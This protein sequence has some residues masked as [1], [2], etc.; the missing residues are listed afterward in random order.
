MLFVPG[1][2]P[3]FTEKALTCEA[4]GIIFDLEDAVAV[5]R[6][7]QAREWVRDALLS[8]DF[9]RKERSVRINGLETGF[10]QDDISA[11]VE[12]RPDSIVLPKVNTPEDVLAADA[13]VSRAESAAGLEPNSVRF[14]AFIESPRGVENA[15][16][17]GASCRRVSGFLFGA[18]DFTR[19]THATITESRIELYY[20]LGRILCAARASGIDALDAPCIQVRDPAANERQARQAML[21][22]YDG[23][24]AIHPDQIA[25][26]NE[27]FTPSPEQVQHWIRVLDAYR[28]AELEGR[29]A[30]T[31]DGQLVEWP[32]IEMSLRVLSIAD[33]AGILSEDERRILLAARS[34]S[35]RDHAA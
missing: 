29:G 3:R 26:I 35:E 19:E 23:K 4:D 21:L 24:L 11:I 22:G 27:V 2:I 18:V 31:L 34:A 10:G 15:F 12:G 13:A 1:G 30:S 7:V 20:A 6:K 5:H 32:H 28:Q 33:A 16:S 17:I 14:L 8:R 9:G 25:A